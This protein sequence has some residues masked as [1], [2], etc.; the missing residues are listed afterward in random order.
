MSSQM[1]AR[2]ADLRSKEELFAAANSRAATA[3]AAVLAAQTPVP[4]V[5]QPTV[6]EWVSLKADL[7]AA[8]DLNFRMQQEGIMLLTEGATFREQH[9][10]LKTKLVETEADYHNA[11]WQVV[12]LGEEVH[13]TKTHVALLD[14]EI[15]NLRAQVTQQIAFSA[16]PSPR[17]SSTR[18]LRW[19]LKE[20][21]IAMPQRMRN[22]LPKC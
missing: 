20:Y 2:D 7:A 11:Q 21:V 4:G 13:A 3:A 18:P 10:V 12:K 17:R 22:N 8:K 6:G 1:S 5:G 15:L 16:M 14:V 9:K 19:P